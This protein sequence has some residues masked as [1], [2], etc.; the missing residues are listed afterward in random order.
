MPPRQKPG[1]SKQDY[2]TP[3]VLLSAIAHRFGPI[4]FDLASSEENRVAPRGW[5]KADNAL[6]QDWRKLR[7]RRGDVAFCNPEFADIEPWAE[8]C[9]DVRLLQRWTLLLAP[10]GTQDWAVKHMWRKSYVLKL[11]GRVAFV[12]EEQGYPKDL[13]VAAYGFGVSGEEVWDWRKQVT[14]AAK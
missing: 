2:R 3:G 5:T 9:A 7:L 13:V 11:R 10:L 6:D 8:C 1:K 14:G 4:G 12:G